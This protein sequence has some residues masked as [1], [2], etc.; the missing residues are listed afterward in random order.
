MPSRVATRRASDTAESEQQPPCFSSSTSSSRGHCWSVTPTTSWPAACRRAAA[1]EESTPPDI[2]TATF[3][4][5][6]DD[7]ALDG[8]NAHAARLQVGHAAVQ[9]IGL[10]GHLQQHP[11]LLAGDVGAADVGDDLVVLAQVVDHGL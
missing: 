4:P 9:L 5:L 2:A 11:T 6:L 7:V 10:A 8:L 1:T 3:I